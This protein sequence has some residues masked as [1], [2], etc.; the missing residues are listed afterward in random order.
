MKIQQGLNN[1]VFFFRDVNM[2][3]G[4]VNNNDIIVQT[5]TEL[6]N[7]KRFAPCKGIRIPKSGKFLLLK[8][9]K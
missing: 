3:F 5:L 7:L 1:L 2:N 8:S 9:R 6:W 4:L